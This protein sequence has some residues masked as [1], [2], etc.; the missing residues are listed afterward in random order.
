[1]YARANV[2]AAFGSVIQAQRHQGGGHLLKIS[3]INGVENQVFHL[4][5][6]Y[7]GPREKWFLLLN[8]Q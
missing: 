7:A 8:L 2:M 3:R 1:M 4:E 5:E 6:E